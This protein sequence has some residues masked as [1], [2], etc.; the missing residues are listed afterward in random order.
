MK[1]ILLT[2]LGA[3]PTRVGLL[4]NN[5]RS[6]GAHEI[7]SI[8]VEHG[9]DATNLD[10]WRT[11]PRDLLINSLLSWFDNDDEPWIGLSGSIDGSSTDEFKLLVADLKKEIP[12]LKVILGGYRV[13]VGEEDWVDV[14]FIGRSVNIFTDW[15]KEKSVDKFLFAVSPPTYKNP[16]HI[17]LEDP[18]APILKDTDFWQPEEVL[19]VETALGCKFN[20]SFCGYDFRNNKNPVIANMDKFINSVQTAHDKFGIS[21]FFLADDTI[22]EVDNKLEFL[23]DVVKEVDFDIEFM[24]FARADVL[25]AKPYQIDMINNAN[26]KTL[27]FGIESMTPGVTKMIRKGGKPEKMFQTL[28][29]FKEASPDT[30]TYGNWIIGLTGDS[31]KDLREQ[32]DRVLEE[33]LLTSAGCNVLRLYTN[34]ENPD[35]MSDIDKDPAKYGYTPLAQDRQ[36]PELGY[37]SHSWKNDWTTSKDAEPLSL[38]WDT[39][40]QHGLTSVFTAHEILSVKAL[41]PNM[42]IANYN[43]MLS[44]LN[45]AQHRMVKKYIQ[46]KSSW[47]LS[48]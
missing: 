8:A 43:N 46:Q 6:S 28:K 35:V 25:G 48:R 44:L 34:L 16:S 36:W 37:A 45:R 15:I 14:A 7:V 22:N 19:S 38:E 17:I 40:M 10:Y 26:I 30:F 9:I 12:Q 11:W 21:N 42:P 29:M 2:D 5:S 3:K 4:H 32:A 47:M 33:Q 24:S 39:R 1:L 13:P 31:E 27:F 20:C 23:Q 41:L 18:V